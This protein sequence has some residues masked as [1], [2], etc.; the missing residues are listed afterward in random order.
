MEKIAANVVK[1]CPAS[2][3]ELLSMPQL[4]KLGVNVGSV[5]YPTPV[6]DGYPEDIQTSIIDQWGSE[7]SN[8]RIEGGCPSAPCNSWWQIVWSKVSHIGCSLNNCG[9]RTTMVCIYSSRADPETDHPFKVG[10]GCSACPEG[11]ERCENKMCASESQNPTEPEFQSEAFEKDED[12]NDNEGY[13]EEE[14]NKDNNSDNNPYAAASGTGGQVLDH[15]SSDS[16][17]QFTVPFAT[18]FTLLLLGIL[19]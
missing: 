4:S 6:R 2:R 10:N 13:K 3:E 1:K 8:Y 12:S 18:F 15:E 9:N 19:A 14:P 16:A 7:R 5:P 17:T 11:F